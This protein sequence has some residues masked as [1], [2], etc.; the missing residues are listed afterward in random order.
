MPNRNRNQVK[1]NA[2]FHFPFAWLVAI[3]LVLKQE[4]IMNI[5]KKKKL[6]KKKKKNMKKYRKTDKCLRKHKRQRF[7]SFFVSI[8]QA[9]LASLGRKWNDMRDRT[10]LR[11]IMASSRPETCFCMS[12]F[13]QLLINKRLS[14]PL[15]LSARCHWGFA[16]VD[17]QR[18]TR[19]CHRHARLHAPC[20]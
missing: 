1:R 4:N 7:D 9:F 18:G 2:C 11:P 19:W 20:G 12:R 15:F 17:V 10:A 8:C 5:Q 14:L 16:Q 13:G 3:F 6:K